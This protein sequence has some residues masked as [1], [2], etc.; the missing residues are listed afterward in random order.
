[1]GFWRTSFFTIPEFDVIQS[2]YVMHNIVATTGD[3]GFLVGFDGRQEIGVRVVHGSGFERARTFMAMET[4]AIVVG[5]VELDFLGSGRSCEVVD[6]NVPQAAELGMQ[7]TKHGVVRV[8][9]VAG[10]GCGHAMVLE[11]GGGEI[12]GII[13]V[14]TFS[15]RFHGVAGK[16]EF[17]GGRSFQLIRNAH[18]HAENRQ[19]E[20]Y[21][22]RRDFA[23]ARYSGARAYE[24]GRDQE[25]A[26]ENQ[27]EQQSGRHGHQRE[28]RNSFK[29][30]GSFRNASY[31]RTT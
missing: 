10:F 12:G 13:H 26:E 5:S 1:M 3:A 31:E 27:D 15:K 18:G 23:G 24:Y 14:E 17:R 29:Q 4:L 7:C 20:E 22:K 8:A 6:I 21:E 11:V 2:G 9:G 30:A 19:A 16:T 28:L 25:Y